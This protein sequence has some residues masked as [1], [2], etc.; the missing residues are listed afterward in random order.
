MNG[1]MRSVNSRCSFHNVS[2]EVIV[3]ML[4]TADLAA[5]G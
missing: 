4:T 1:S 2:P 5:T 3:L